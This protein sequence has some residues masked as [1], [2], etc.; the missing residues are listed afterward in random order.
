[1]FS[2]SVSQSPKATEI[3]TKVN[4]HDLINLTNIAEETINKTKDNVQY[5]RK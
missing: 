1:M 3:R 4:N 2:W 5:G